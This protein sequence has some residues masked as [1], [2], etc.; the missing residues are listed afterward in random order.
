MGRHEGPNMRVG[1]ILSQL[2]IPD[3]DYLGWPYL[4]PSHDKGSLEI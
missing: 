4:T 2:F 1:S 3:N